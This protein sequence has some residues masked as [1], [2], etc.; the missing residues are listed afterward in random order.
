MEAEIDFLNCFLPYFYKTIYFTI[1]CMHI[2]T[3]MSAYMSVC[4]HMHRY[5]RPCVCRCLR[6][7]RRGHQ[8]PWGWSACEPHTDVGE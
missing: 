1:V 6:K 4:V 3:R 2:H 7:S 5:I 8:I